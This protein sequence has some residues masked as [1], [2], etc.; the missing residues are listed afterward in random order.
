MNNNGTNI[1]WYAESAAAWNEALPL[2]NGRVGAMV[3][4]GAKHER[5]GLNEDTLWSGKPTFYSIENGPAT[6][7]QMRDLALQRKYPE[8]Q[9]IADEKFTNLWSQMYLPLGELTIDMSHPDLVENYS[10]SLDISKGIH[11][12]E[13]DCGGVHYT[14]EYFISNSDQ[15]MV[16]KLSA[17][18]PKALTF[19]MNLIPALHAF[20]E[21]TKNCASIT[22][23]CP[24]VVREFGKHNDCR[25]EMEY[26]Q[27]DEDK[28]IG[29]YAEARIS[30][31]GGNSSLSGV[32]FVEKADSA[33]IYFNVRTSFNGWDKHPVLEG[34]PFIEPCKTELDAAMAKGYDDIKAIHIA[35]HSELYDRVSL[36]LGGGNEKFEATD[37]RLYAHENGGE[38]PALYA[39]YFNFGRYLTIAASR[40][41][42][43]PT[44]LQGIWNDRVVAP[45]NSNYTVNINT[46]MN[47]WPT[48]MVDLAECNEPLLEMIEEM[49]VSGARTAENYYG[50]PGFV[51][52][53]NC[54]LWRL[55]TP[56]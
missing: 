31:D 43:Q 14:R 4:G 20:S 51:C 23:N 53:H 17:D 27:T 46:E 34:K 16:I 15:V 10:R 50:A 18:K 35:D 5:I 13:Y 21:K 30:T 24:I 33:V 12:V 1:L 55:T 6:F 28:G 52:H 47:Y 29:Y 19:S 41:G 26:G 2:G 9:K 32:L 37:K 42:T 3:Y 45:W 49:A 22:G 25:G 54:D 11:T 38:D 7:R 40:K 48:M 8:A 39:L 56:V 36:D 44:N